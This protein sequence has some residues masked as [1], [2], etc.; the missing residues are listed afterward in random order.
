MGHRCD[1][2]LGQIFVLQTQL[3]KAQERM[4]AHSRRMG[5]ACRSRIARVAGGDDRCNERLDNEDLSLRDSLGAKQR[6]LA[7]REQLSSQGHLRN[8][9]IDSSKIG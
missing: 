2:L 5:I 7:K 3:A 6:S 4:C 8:I 9:E 1:S